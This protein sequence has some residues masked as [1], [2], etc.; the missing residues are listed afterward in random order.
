MNIY[1]FSQIENAILAIYPD[2]EKEVFLKNKEKGIGDERYLWWELS[3]CLL[4]SQ[5]PYSVAVA[6]ANA[7]DRHGILYEQSASILLDE[8]ELSRILKDEVVVDGKKRTY[9][10]YLSR[11]K[12]LAAAHQVIRAC[13]GLKAVLCDIENMERT[14][15]W[16][17]QNVPGLGP[18]QASMFLRNIGV[19]YDFAIIDRHVIQYMGM[20]NLSTNDA[21]AAL[22]LSGY[23]RDEFLL[24]A[25]AE[26]MGV[27]VGLM[28][29]AIWIVMRAAKNMEQEV[30]LI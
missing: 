21:N 8:T 14:R 26:R 22:G 4:S 1:N 10:F 16:F 7:I 23:K 20:M 30:L 25:H 27:V 19:S 6:A 3:C 13:G 29:W 2:I 12:Q 28:D 17:I 15:D 18:K 11:A 5:V 9:R 24:K